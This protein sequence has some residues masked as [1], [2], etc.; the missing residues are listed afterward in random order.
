M[1]FSASIL[2]QEKKLS[3]NYI[4]VEVTKCSKIE[5]QS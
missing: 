5:I 4:R 1:D 2:T 3:L